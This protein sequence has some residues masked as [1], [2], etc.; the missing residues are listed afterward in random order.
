MAEQ[1]RNLAEQSCTL[2]RLQVEQAVEAALVGPVVTESTSAE[3][4]RALEVA[5]KHE[6]TSLE[7][8]IHNTQVR[9]GC[10]GY[11]VYALY[12]LYCSH[13]SAC[14]RTSALCSRW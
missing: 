5:A 3:Y 11:A 7:E 9:T 13:W 1:A 10:A 6:Q 4:A 12:A 14:Y 2:T 8:E